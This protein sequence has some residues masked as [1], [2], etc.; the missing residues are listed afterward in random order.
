[1]GKEQLAGPMAS[2]QRTLMLFQQESK[3]VNGL[4]R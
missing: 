3:H 1:M 4:Q 2:A